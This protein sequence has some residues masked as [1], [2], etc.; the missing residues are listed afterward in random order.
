MK[1]NFK[2][3]LLSIVAV[4]VLAFEIFFPAALA[5]RGPHLRLF[6]AIADHNV[7]L[8]TINQLLDDHP[9]WINLCDDAGRLPIHAAAEARR[10]EVVKMLIEERGVGVNTP[11]PHGGLTPLWFAISEF[12]F[13]Y[14]N[15]ASI[16]EYL[17]SRGANIGVTN[18]C[19][20]SIFHL[21]IEDSYKAFGPKSMRF[22]YNAFKDKCDFGSV[23]GLE[24]LRCGNTPLGYALCTHK[25]N[26]AMALIEIGADVKHKNENGEEPL[27]ALMEHDPL[28]PYSNDDELTQL[29]DAMVQ[30][31]ADLNCKNIHGDTLYDY[32]T[33][34]RS[35]DTQQA[36]Y[37]RGKWLKDYCKARGIALQPGKKSLDDGEL[38]LEGCCTLL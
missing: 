8:V 1:P 25:Y 27:F 5:I 18:C 28:P 30:R 19:E 13:G 35:G 9:D 26:T 37:R 20:G 34:L 16:S 21:F 2:P 3:K 31:G 22:L 29:V 4:I 33:D 24:T 38:G 15:D 10:L 36:A 17:V 23:F 11:G 7:P 32:A 14:Y 12:D 6:D